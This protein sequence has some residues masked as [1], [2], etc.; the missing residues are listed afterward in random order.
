[1]KQKEKFHQWTGKNT[2]E[3]GRDKN[4]V[5]INLT[6]KELHPAIA[7]ALSKDLNLAHTSS[8][9]QTTKEIISGMERA[10]HHLPSELEEV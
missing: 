6:E 3:K 1:M 9:K 5:M 4:K 7:T 10:I 2:H 8:L